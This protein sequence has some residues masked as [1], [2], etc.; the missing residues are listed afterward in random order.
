MF[1]IPSFLAFQRTSLDYLFL[2]LHHQFLPI[3]CFIPMRRQTCINIIYFLKELLWL[4]IPF[5]H[6]PL[7]LF[8]FITK[9]PESVVY[10]TY[11]CL[12]STIP[13]THSCW[14][15]IH[16]ISCKVSSLALPPLIKLK[17]LVFLRHQYR[18]LINSRNRSQRR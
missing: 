12:S 1:Q 11:L 8:P 17:L 14:V 15:S 2:L 7:F 13:P 4:C 3:F 6:C 16:T 9:L 18:G 10:G 5:P